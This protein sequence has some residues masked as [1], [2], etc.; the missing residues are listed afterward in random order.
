MVLRPRQPKTANMV[1]SAAADTAA[2]RVLLSPFSKP[3]AFSDADKYVAWHDA[4]CDEIKA[5][6]SNH[7][8]SLVPF[9]PSMNVVG[10]RWI[11]RI[12]RRIDGSIDRY[13]ARLVA[14]GFT[15]QEGID[16]SETFSPVIKQ[17][18]VRLVF[19]I[20]VSCNWKIHQLDIHI[21]FLNGVLIEEVYMKQPL[22][23]VDPTLPSHVC[24][25][26]KSLYGLKQASRAWYTRLSDFLLSIGFLASKVDTSLFIL[27]D[28]TNI[29]YLLVYVDDIL[30]TGSNLGCSC[31]RWDR[32]LW[33]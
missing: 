8:W 17:A 13:K 33:V 19:F 4:M 23:F 3:I 29:F 15:Q 32:R 20:A 2:T 22:G 30:L 24:R 7:T 18:T 9:H 1:A 28:G 21:A 12:K 27:S 14:R 10:S 16:Y 6:R 5:F 26:H 31:S 11:Y 25:L